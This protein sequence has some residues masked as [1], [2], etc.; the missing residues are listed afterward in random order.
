V[1]PASATADGWFGYQLALHPDGNW[2]AAAAKRRS[3]LAE[4]VGVGRPLLDLRGAC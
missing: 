1:W 4:A 2:L 3:G